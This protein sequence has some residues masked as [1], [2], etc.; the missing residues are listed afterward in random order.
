MA[1]VS[2]QIGRRGKAQHVHFGVRMSAMR[3]SERSMQFACCTCPALRLL[4]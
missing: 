3:V 2:A 4:L 1:I